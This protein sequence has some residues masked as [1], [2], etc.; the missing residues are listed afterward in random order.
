MLHLCVAASAI[1]LTVA[2]TPEPSRPTDVRPSELRFE[3]NCGQHPSEVR[4]VARTGDASLWLTPHAAMLELGQ[5]DGR[6]LLAI[7]LGPAPRL[8][9]VEGE[10]LLPGATSVFHGQDPAAW[11]RGARGFGRAVYRDVTPG[12]DIA[13]R[14]PR[15]DAEATAVEFDVLVGPGA[16]LP[17]PLL[18]YRGADALRIRPDGGLEVRAGAATVVQRPPIAWQ[19]TATGRVPVAARY[20][21]RGGDAVALALG[22]RD[23]RLP[24]VVDPV[25]VFATYHGGSTIDQGFSIA[26]DAAGNVYL[27]GMSYSTD[28]PLAGPAPRSFSRPADMVITK[29]TPDGLTRLYST[30]LGGDLDDYCASLVVDASGRAYIGGATSSTDFPTVAAAQ[31]VPGGRDDGVVAVLAADG[32]SIELATYVGG[33]GDDSVLNVAIDRA[34]RLWLTGFTKSTDLPVVAPLQPALRGSWDAMVAR[35]SAT[36]TLEL[37]SWLGGGG[38]ERSDGLAADASG[39]VLL[40]GYTTSVDFPVTPGVVQPARSGTSDAFVTRLDAGGTL[41]WSTYLGGSG[42]DSAFD[43]AEESTGEV[44][45][46]GGTRSDDFPTPGGVQT[47]RAGFEDAI[48]ARLAADASAVRYGTYL[49]GSDDDVL[50]RLALAPGG[51]IVAIG[52]TSSDDLYTVNAIQSVPGSPSWS[53]SHMAFAVR[54]AAGGTALRWSTYLG[55]SGDSIGYGVAITADADT[56]LSGETEGSDF[57]PLRAIQPALAGSADAF[58]L[59][60]SE[61]CAALPAVAELRARRLMPSLLQVELTWPAVGGE[62]HMVWRVTEKSSIPAAGA[63]G[64]PP[65][66]TPALFCSPTTPPRCVDYDPTPLVFYQVRARCSGAEG[67]L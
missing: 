64:A 60:L 1:A 3:E 4:F 58:F 41:V 33:S 22:P 40:T 61:D 30:Y 53:W 42:Y 55:G 45:I 20:V 50:L 59:R 29:F 36:G 2:S 62:D 56:L 21:R 13:F 32:G 9:R 48:V 65:V 14:A 23:R 26:S 67:P 43:V 12:V 57:L 10:A 19:E 52:Y 47:V 25:I 28:Y 16:A 17:D 38:D 51:D 34:G 46:V 5:T 39:G 31:P 11:V 27:A 15:G 18:R 6:D 24:L 35:Y 66:V 37:L 49:G 54:L 44:W 63:P 7:E 8:L